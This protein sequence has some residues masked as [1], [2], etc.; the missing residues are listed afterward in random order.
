MT[1]STSHDTLPNGYQLLWYRI[2]HILGR[3]SFGV[4]Y[5]ATDTNLDRQVAVKEYFPLDLS[6]RIENQ[7]VQAISAESQEMYGACLQRF[8]TEA[9]TLAKFNH[10]NIVRVHNV[11]ESNQTAYMAM[12]YEHGESLD[13]LIRGQE[14]RE[15][16]R[17]LKI[18]YPMLDALEYIHGLGFIHRDVKPSNI[19]V[20]Q[21]DSPVLLDFGSTRITPNRESRT[22][23][24]FVSRGY[25]PHEQYS[26]DAGKQGQWSD[27]YALGATFYALVCNRPPIDALERA[28]AR[29][30]G[31]DDPL[32]PASVLCAN[33][34]SPEFLQAIDKAMNVIPADRPENIGSLRILFP[35]LNPTL[36]TDPSSG[37]PPNE[38]FSAYNTNSPP[39]SE[40]DSFVTL[41]SEIRIESSNNESTPYNGT[42]AFLRKIAVWSIVSIL[43]L[44]VLA[45]FLIKKPAFF[46]NEKET[47]VLSP[48]DRSTTT[49][50]NPKP[51]E[52]E[53]EEKLPSDDETTF[54]DT[55]ADGSEGPEMVIIPGKQFRT[56]VL[57]SQHN[58]ISFPAPN[59]FALG[60]YE[61]T[62]GEYQQFVDATNSRL[63]HDAGWGRDSRPVMNVSWHDAIAYTEWLSNQTS[64]QYRLPTEAEWKFAA[65]AEIDTAYWWGDD[66]GFAR[67]NCNG[68]GSKWDGNMTA[69]AGSFEPNR[70]GIYDTAGNVW[71]WVQDCSSQAEA[72][73]A[74]T[75]W[76]IEQCRERVFLGGAWNSKPLDLI[77]SKRNGD[78]PE[79]RY[80]YLGF[81]V[82]RDM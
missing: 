54:H 13:A 68:C 10:P 27:I 45:W 8:Q 47:Q 42:T 12:A 53:I 20:R 82:A 67:A 66:T 19:F 61:I 1:P 79:L 14:F 30:E 76:S 32:I 52:A 50:I 16:T 9:R 80:R 62:F 5:L 78:G 24:Q 28:N 75:E 51:K 35:A 7:F 37:Q 18:L 43:A 65:W 34:Y 70:F 26:G 55:L 44:F 39:P 64:K 33:A 48:Q 31:K 4:T 46:T 40:R 56:S 29:L 23:T 21:N 71:E 63:P 49:T 81:R 72:F 41:P 74:D 73:I 15:E 77:S 2:E 36:A 6:V 25:A 22:L 58:D 3:G 11:F 59:T 57:K 60:R 38:S 69:P 17:I